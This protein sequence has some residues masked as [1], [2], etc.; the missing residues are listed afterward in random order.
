MKNLWPK[1]FPALY[2]FII[3]GTLRVVNDT[4]GKGF[5]FWERPLYVN[6]IEIFGV[7]LV[8]YLFTSI[9]KRQERKYFINDASEITLKRF[10]KELLNVIGVALL[11]VNCTII[12][13]AAVT[14]DGLSLSDFVQ[15]NII[16]TLYIVLYFTIR[17]G[18]FYVQAFVQSKIK[19]QQ[20]ENDRLNSELNFLK[21]QFSP[22]FL[23]NG[24]NNIYFQ[25]DQSVPEAK[26]S[27][28]KLSELLRYS[29]Y[30]D[31]QKLVD[32]SKEIEFIKL[33]SEVHKVRKDD[34]MQLRMDLKEI[35]GKIYPHLIIPLVE[36]AF[37]YVEGSKPLIEIKLKEES[38]YVVFTVFNSK[39]AVKTDDASRSGIG[40]NNLRR[41]LDLLYHQNYDLEILDREHTFEVVLKLPIQ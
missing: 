16:P 37:K 9:I 34:R 17:R 35:K 5:K 2:G 32:I 22:H 31:Q 15:I 30:Q 24:L 3:Y 8:G 41:R 26:K 12:P 1:I 38:G 11:V 4:M 6:I 28:E 23:F 10:S 39:R 13:M 21:E 19:L 14:D 27:V 36:N 33:Y 20:I 18:N 29:L 25:M 7:I 40:L